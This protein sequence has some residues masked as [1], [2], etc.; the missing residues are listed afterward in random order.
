MA[1]YHGKVVPVYHIL[2]TSKSSVLYTEVFKRLK[3]RAPACNPTTI[4]IDFEASLAL[5]LRNV[6][7]GVRI[8]GCRFHYGQAVYRKIKSSDLA[9]YYNS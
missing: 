3:E 9:T 7:P 8:A 5:A 4:M 2:M 1:D 6:Y